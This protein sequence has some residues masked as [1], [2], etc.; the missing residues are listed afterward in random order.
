MKKLKLFLM[1]LIV[2]LSFG[3]VD[4]ANAATGSISSTTTNHAI[5]LSREVTGVTNKVTNTFTYTVTAGSNPSG[6]TDI[7]TTKTIVFN[8]ATPSSNKVTQ[9]ATLDFAGATFTT[10]GDYTYTIKETGSSDSTTYPVDSSNTYTVK[11]SVRN[12]SETDFTSDKKVTMILFKGE[13]GSA[14]KLNNTTFNFTKEAVFRTITIAKTVEGTMA[15][16][17]TYFA[18]AVTIAGSDGNTYS[19]SGQTKS[20][21]STTITQGT[22]GTIYLKHGETVT[23]SG[24][25]NGST[26]SFNETAVS[27]YATYINGSTTNSTSSGSKTV[28][29]TNSNTIKNVYNASAIT[30]LFTRFTP[31]IIMSAAAIIGVTLIAVRQVRYRRLEALEDANL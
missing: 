4:I 28:G 31:Y 19:V 14:T 1:A 21:A 12:A 2:G 7:P 23:I 25:K 13:G 6:A 27:G 29:A 22:A 10:N 18:V 5:T 30:G 3:N 15:D 8:G 9:S 11:I 24:V 20:G 26:Y 17:D 16:P